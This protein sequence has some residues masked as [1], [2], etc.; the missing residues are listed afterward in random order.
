MLRFDSNNDAVGGLS[1]V[2]GTVEARV[3]LGNE[4]ELC[5]FTDSGSLG[6]YQTPNIPDGFRT[7]I[8]LGLRYLT[9]IGPVGLV[10]GYK[11]DR[12]PGE[13]PGRFHISI[14]YTF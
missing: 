14:G 2:S 4:I 6:R 10:Y 1:S 3:E 12:E 8:G 11:L 9:P 13:D 5:I 7:S